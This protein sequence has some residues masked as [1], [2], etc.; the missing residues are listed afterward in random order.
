MT[1]L[2]NIELKLNHMENQIT[3][4]KRNI[5]AMDLKIQLVIECMNDHNMKVGGKI[6]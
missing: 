1:K 4:I 3:K 2:T 5:D 6:T